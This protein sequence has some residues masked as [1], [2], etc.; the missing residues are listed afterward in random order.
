MIPGF[1][2]VCWALGCSLAWTVPGMGQVGR[3]PVLGLGADSADGHVVI[4]GTRLSIIPPY[5]WAQTHAFPGLLDS[6]GSS[7][8]QVYDLPDGN[9][10]RDGKSFSRESFQ[11]KGAKVLSFKELKISGFPAKY[12][13][14]E[15]DSA[16]R[17]MALIF[18]D[19]SFSAT[20]IGLYP[21]SSATTGEAIRDAYATISYKKSQVIDP[22]ETAPFSLDTGA[23]RFR[24]AMFSK[25]LYI[26]SLDGRE[27]SEGSPFLTVTPYPRK[28]GVSLQDVSEGLIIKEMQNGLESP[29]LDNISLDSVNGCEAYEVEIHCQLGGQKGVLYQ[30]LASK[31]EHTIVIEGV[32]NNDIEN[33]LKSFK[34]LA[35]TIRIK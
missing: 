18:G 8:I 4:S 23:S 34:S 14:M 30:F 32:T 7:V 25:P 20:L 5:G 33:N 15:G 11:A 1:F 35:H 28:A 19:S 6:S 29:Q 16:K 12:C 24:F 13:Y 21:D 22:F 2:R 31:G 17:I 3:A 27:P 10:F 26:Y 9:F